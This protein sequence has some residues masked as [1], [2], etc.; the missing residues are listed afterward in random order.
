[1]ID[2]LLATPEP[3]GPLAVHLTE[4][5]GPLT[6]ERP[7][8]RYEFSKPEY[9]ALSAGQKM[10]LRMGPDNERRLKAK[11]REFRSL[12]ASGAAGR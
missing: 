1:M 5:K 9:E 4:V 10:L 3:N 8:V 11:L 2:Q 12:A 6:S 7:W